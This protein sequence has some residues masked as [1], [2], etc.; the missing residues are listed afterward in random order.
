[1]GMDFFILVDNVGK[2]GESPL[3][4]VKS[5]DKPVDSVDIV[6]ITHLLLSKSCKVSLILLIIFLFLR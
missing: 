3:T 5:V 4:R 6:T 2:E 1:M